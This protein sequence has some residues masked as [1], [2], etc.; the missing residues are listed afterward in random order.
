[1]RSGSMLNNG[2]LVIHVGKKEE[3]EKIEE[4]ASLQFSMS[5]LCLRLKMHLDRQMQ[6][7]K[8]S[9]RLLHIHNNVMFFSH[10]APSFQKTIT[11]DRQSA[12]E[13]CSRIATLERQRSSS[14]LLPLDCVWDIWSPTVRAIKLMGQICWPSKGREEDEEEKMRVDGGETWTSSSAMREITST[15]R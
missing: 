7:I 3:L 13:R 10:L 6:L 1:M 15:A 2:C 5:H 14:C 12:K 8:G 9:P 4:E 11:A